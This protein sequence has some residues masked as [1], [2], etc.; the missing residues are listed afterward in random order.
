MKKILYTLALAFPLL[1]TSCL[2]EEKEFFDQTPAERMDAFLAEYK[3]VL[4]SSETGWLFECYPESHQKYGGYAYVLKFEEGYVT[5][6]FEFADEA[7]ISTYKMTNDDG[8]VI[9]F[10]TY[11]ENLHFFANPSASQYQ[12]Y[13]GDYEY[14]LLGM[15]A[16]KSEI[17]VKGRKSGNKLTLRKFTG[18]DPAEYFAAQTAISEIMEAPAAKISIAGEE[19]SC[20]IKGNVFSMGDTQCAYCF[21]DKGIRFYEPVEIG[22]TEYTEL[23]YANETYVSED[24]K[25]VISL[26]FPPVNEQFVAGDWILDYNSSSEYAKTLFVKGFSAVTAKG[27][28]FQ[29]AFIGD[30]YYGVWGF[31]VNFGGYGGVVT[32]DAAT[33]GENLLTLTATGFGGNGSTFYGWGLNYAIVPLGGG[34]PVTFTVEANNPRKPTLFTLT[35]VDNPENVIVFVE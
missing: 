1:A 24:S 26:V 6:Y 34:S 31:N 25:V 35:Q 10:D 19:T 17:Y 30:D 13:Q 9:A 14:N 28:P 2:M 12:G 11:N 32:F 8:P 15:S 7:A 23:T 3:S 18:T 4:E 27:Y 20:S 29:L 16:D 21:T 33:E 22:G 5:A